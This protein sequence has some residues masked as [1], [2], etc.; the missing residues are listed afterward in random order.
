[1]ESI[2]HGGTF[3]ITLTGHESSSGTIARVFRPN[4]DGLDGAL[5]E[6]PGRGAKLL[7][8]ASAKQR[9]IALVGDLSKVETGVRELNV[10]D[11]ILIDAEG[12][13][14]AEGSSTSRK[15]RQKRW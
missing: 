10:G 15:L 5:Y 8:D 4:E 7:L 1:M 13:H 11:V 3:I 9:V 2:A 12:I 6:R 14:D